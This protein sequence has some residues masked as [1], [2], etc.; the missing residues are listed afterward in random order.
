MQRRHA[1]QGALATLGALVLPPA[2]RADGLAT[3]GARLTADFDPVATLWLG[4]DIGHETFTADMAAALWTHVPIGMLVRG[5]DAEKRARLLLARRGLDP[6]QVQ[7][8][9]DPQAPFFMRDPVVFGLDGEDAA[10]VVD[11]QW[12]HYG[13]RHWCRRV[14]PDDPDEA[15]ACARTDDVHTGALDRRFAEAL[16]MGM[17]RSPLAIEGG[18]IEVNGH[19]LLIANAQ[20]WRSRN[21]G[22]PPLSL[23]KELLRLPGIRKVIWLP[24][25]LAQDPL[26]RGTITGPYVG[27]GTG[28]HTDE[29]VRFADPR[30]VL[31]AWAGEADMRRH[32][33]A[34][35]NQA[36]MQVN[37]D[38][39]THSTDQDGNPLRVIKV[40][41]PRTIERTVVLVP[42][43]GSRDSAQWSPGQFPPREGHRVGESVRQVAASSYLNHLVVNDLVL[44]PDYLPYGTPPRRQEEVRQIYESVF[45]GR[46]VRF[47]DAMNANWVG[48]GIHCAT[49]S[50]PKG[51]A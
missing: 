27:W 48:G 9:H 45:P 39:L 25:G 5:E 43:D 3:A 41:L 34:R 22:L 11:F 46:T 47:I 20:L 35:L 2:A 37:Y 18:G 10:F 30:T 33:V 8:V 51:A 6:R 31:L 15:D 49:L 36:R 17:F 32:P 1:L 44:L 24:R 50:E 26:H 16:G 19:G 14:H 4:H 40:P 7:F 28:G 13:W 29:F 12:T 21:P 38:M 42:D 23:E